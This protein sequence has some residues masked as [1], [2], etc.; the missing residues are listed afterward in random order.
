M[1]DFRN[2]IPNS[3]IIF[4]LV[5][6]QLNQNQCIA[7]KIKP[8]QQDL[9]KGSYFKSRTP[10]QSRIKIED[11]EQKIIK[12]DIT[13]V[14]VAILYGNVIQY[15]IIEEIYNRI[16][17]LTEP[18]PNAFIEDSEGNKL[19]FKHVSFVKKTLT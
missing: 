3:L 5:L 1:M 4:L 10:E 19:Y 15:D 11:I 14:L 8:I 7:Q 2:V 17:S 6:I 16:R 9:K 12:Y 18:Y 13:C